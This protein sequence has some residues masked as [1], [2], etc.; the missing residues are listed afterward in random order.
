MLNEA[1]E[2]FL[3]AGNRKTA[4]QEGTNTYIPKYNLGVIYEC[5]GKKDDAVKWYSDC[6]EYEPAKERLKNLQE[7]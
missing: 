6:G 2:M 5:L 3:E 1:A 4:I 7:T